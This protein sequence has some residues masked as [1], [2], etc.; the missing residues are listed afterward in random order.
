MLQ[1]GCVSTTFLR[2]VDESHLEECYNGSHCVMSLCA[3]ALSNSRNSFILAPANHN[4]SVSV[5][6]EQCKNHAA[7]RALKQAREGQA[8]TINW[9]RL[10]ILAATRNQHMLSKGLKLLCPEQ[11]ERKKTIEYTCTA[12]PATTSSVSAG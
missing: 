2:I 4:Y 1:S 9:H 10:T 7:F 5:K 8:T 12:Q 3:T 6:R 11:F